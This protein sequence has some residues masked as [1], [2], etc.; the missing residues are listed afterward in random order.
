M[1][2]TLKPSN[3]SHDPLPN[4]FNQLKIQRSRPISIVPKCCLSVAINQWLCFKRL[5]CPPQS[6]PKIFIYLSKKKKQKNRF[7]VLTC[8]CANY[9]PLCCC[10][11]YFYSI[12][13]QP[14]MM[15]LPC[16]PQWIKVWSGDCPARKWRLHTTWMTPDY[17]S[18]LAVHRCIFSVLVVLSLA[19]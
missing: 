2:R 15:L 8:L 7:Y 5:S 17:S 12:Y 18:L 4:T 1:E 10:E 11:I 3:I 6:F 14:G 9:F 19:S 13:L 16:I